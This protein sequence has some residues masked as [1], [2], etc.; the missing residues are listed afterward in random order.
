M[1][2]LMKQL[3]VTRKLK[4]LSKVYYLDKKSALLLATSKHTHIKRKGVK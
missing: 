3:F 1:A 2:I 4:F